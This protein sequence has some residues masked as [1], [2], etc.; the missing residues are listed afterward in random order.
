MASKENF[1]RRKHERVSTRK[2]FLGESG[3]C[4]FYS[5][6]GQTRTGKRGWETKCLLKRRQG[7]MN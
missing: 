7:K 3:S 1:P 6:S 5:K 4:W 2:S